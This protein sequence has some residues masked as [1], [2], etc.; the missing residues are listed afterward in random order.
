[1]RVMVNGKIEDIEP[2]AGLAELV[3]RCGLT[4]ERVAV[5]VNREL[6]RR[7]DYARTELREGDRVEI[8]TFVG[9]G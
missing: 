1:M 8:V 7:A 2:G 4:P 9:G 5:E 3:Q 6:V